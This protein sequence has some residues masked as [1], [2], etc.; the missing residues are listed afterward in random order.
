MSHLGAFLIPYFLMLFGAGLP[1]LFLELSIG[2]FSSLGCIG[3]WKMCPLFKGIGIA[4]LIVSCFIAI[5]YNMITAWA[6]YYLIAS[7]GLSVPWSTCSND[8]N[9]QCKRDRQ[10]NK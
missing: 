5:Y 10:I 6:I 4:M 2:Q 9:T 8:W 7:I 1:I 3:V